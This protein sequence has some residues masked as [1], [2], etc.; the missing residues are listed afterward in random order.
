[1]DAAV[2]DGRIKEPQR[3][4]Y[5]NL[6]KS[7]PVN[8]E[9]ALKALKPSRRVMDDLHNPPAGNESPWEKRMKEIKNN[10]KK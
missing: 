6:L 9:S 3:E 7:D 10:L 5:L 2:K 4:V 8:G 1:M